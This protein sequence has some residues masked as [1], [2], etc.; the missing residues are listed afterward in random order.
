MLS[1]CVIR[2]WEQCAFLHYDLEKKSSLQG[3]ST[4][5]ERCGSRAT[6]GG[7]EIGHRATRLYEASHGW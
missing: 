7:K 4:K 6:F 5:K 3:A 2:S 1:F